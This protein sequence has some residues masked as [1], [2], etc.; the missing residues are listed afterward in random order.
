MSDATQYQNSSS[1][2]SQSSQQSDQDTDDVQLIIPEETQQKFP[3]LVIGIK[4]SK[5]MDN[6]ERNYWLQVLPVMTGEQVDE[7]KD[8]L[9]T[10]KKKLAEIEQKY[11]SMPTEKTEKKPE[12]TP[13]EKKREAEK[14]RQWKLQQQE[15]E[16]LAR[17]EENVE[18]ILSQLSFA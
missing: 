16:R 3:Q 11:A 1:Q 8:I 15:K 10:E 7:L 18:D 6:K 9:S 4:E 17:K 14:L 12:K 2:S 13:E 5:S